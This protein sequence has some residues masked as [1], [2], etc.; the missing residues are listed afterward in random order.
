MYAFVPCMSVFVLRQGFA[1]AGCVRI[2]QGVTPKEQRAEKAEEKNQELE[3]GLRMMS[4][5]S[6][7]RWLRL[8]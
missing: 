5:A 6:D 7:S 8:F 1:R 3:A 2:L 4:T